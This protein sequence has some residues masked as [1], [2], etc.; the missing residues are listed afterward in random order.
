M[1]IKLSFILII[2]FLS[3]QKEKSVVLPEDQKVGFSIF[4]AKNYYVDELIALKK[5][6][7]NDKKSTLNINYKIDWETY[8]S[9][10]INDST[11]LMTVRLSSFSKSILGNYGKSFL[12]FKKVKKKITGHIINIQPN[13]NGYDYF[14]VFNLNG[15]FVAG[16]KT[17]NENFIASFDYKV[18]NNG[19]KVMDSGAK[20][21]NSC[22]TASISVIFNGTL[23]TYTEYYCSVDNPNYFIVMPGSGGGIPFSNA[24]NYADYLNSMTDN[25]G[26]DI[27]SGDNDLD[28]DNNTDWSGAVD[29]IPELITLPNGKTIKV[30]F[31]IAKSDAKSANNQISVKLLDALKSLLNEVSSN[32]NL[33]S[34][35]ISATTNG[36]HSHD[37]NHYKGLAIDISKINGTPV[38]NL[39]ANNMLIISMQNAF[40]NIPGRRENYGP[41]FTKKLGIAHDPGISHDDH[42]HF[43]VNGD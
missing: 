10:F 30:T 36:G 2:F 38:I 37:S 23:Y 25:L 29:Y 32:S 27:Y 15:D 4:E 18:D 28:F 20:K 8:K 21:V 39:G 16:V 24:V 33:T 35:H 26:F 42:L 17:K 5:I 13:V 3:C 43:S 22:Q 14:G 31:G 19:L 12:L 9:Y 41:V 6:E 11:D 34:I 7:S 1:K 40:E